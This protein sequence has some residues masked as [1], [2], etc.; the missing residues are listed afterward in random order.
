VHGSLGISDEMPFA[1]QVLQSF[2]MGL[3]DG[4]VEVHKVTVA[5]QILRDYQ[6]SNSLFPS[7]HLLATRERAIEKYGAELESLDNEG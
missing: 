5:R 4:P 2:H 3:A 1:D 6:P 7:Y